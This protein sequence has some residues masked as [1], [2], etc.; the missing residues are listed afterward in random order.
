MTIEDRLR[1]TL[2]DLA[3]EARPV[4]FLPRLD[5]SVHRASRPAV[6]RRMSLVLAA[7]VAAA[8]VGTALLL[9]GEGA[10]IEPVDRPPKVVRLA[11]DSS[12][13]PGRVHL[14]VILAFEAKHQDTAA[15]VLPAKEERAVLLPA[16]RRVPVAWTQHLSTDGT[17]LVTVEP[18]LQ[19]DAGSRARPLEH[20]NPQDIVLCRRVCSDLDHFSTHSTPGVPK[21]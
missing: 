3:D 19:I 10:S 21:R 12:P 7:I 9:R 13:A 8:T 18:G 4:D 20:K 2:R 17:R 14:A 1:T 16:S 5:A 6:R 11:D 15:Y